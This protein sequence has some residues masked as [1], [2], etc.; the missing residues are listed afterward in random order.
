MNFALESTSESSPAR[1]K[2][3][4]V[5]GAGGNAVNRMIEAGLRG[6]EFISIN[7]DLQVLERNLAEVKI[8][9]GS[10]TTRGLGAGANPDRG[11][12]SI[13]ESQEIVAEKLKGAD[14]VF[15]TA[16]MGGGTGTGAAPVVAEIARELGILT[17]AV[18]TRP[19]DWEGMV[20][21]RNARD[22]LA[23]LRACVDT[24]IVIPNQKL[25]S[26]ASK[27]MTMREA[28]RTADEVLHNAAR[29]ISEMIL[30]PG[31]MNVDFADVSAIMR[32]SGQALMGS[33]CA[34][35]EGR[36][37]IA[38]EQALHCPLLD[39]VDIRG[40][41]GML[42]NITGGQILAFEINEVMEYFRAAV[43][44]EA[45]ENIIFGFGEDDTSD[46]FRVT[47]IATGFDPDMQNLPQTNGMP[48]YAQPQAPQP[49][50]WRQAP[51][52]QPTYQAPPPVQAPAAQSGT[53]SWNAWQQ[54]APAEGT[55]AGTGSIA[56]RG[57]Q[58]PSGQMPVAPQ[59]PTTTRGLRRDPS[60]SQVAVAPLSS[61]PRGIFVPDLE[62]DMDDDIEKPAYLRQRG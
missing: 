34:T 46:E 47:L 52:P 61:R 16:G 7:T 9:I 23:A 53:S 30:R 35:G 58:R 43:G 4:G 62:D 5:G 55:R 38:A 33:G 25:L 41:R 1:I 44:D 10:A 27:T 11:R 60:G 54:P 17:V 29:G 31:E 56:A 51:P 8:Q 6:V 21:K 20:R 48:A 57:A 19:F 22:G 26:V 28:F 59:Q 40:A 42:V 15:I 36:A 50:S 37:R 32:E 24:M 49:Q 13:E 12:Q 18:V 45:D 14:M 2:V 3:V 39:A